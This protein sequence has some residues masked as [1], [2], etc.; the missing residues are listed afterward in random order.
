MKK[1]TLLTIGLMVFLCLGLVFNFYPQ[2]V[3]ADTTST[4]TIL[5]DRKDIG[6]GSVS[7]WLKVDEKTGVPLSLGVS[8][9]ETGL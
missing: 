8:L 1:R 4:K 5:C 6:N 9:T 2:P 7:T 3:L